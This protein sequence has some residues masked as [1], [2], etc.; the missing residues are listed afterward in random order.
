[1]SLI[2]IG[3]SGSNK[4][5]ITSYCLKRLKQRNL[6]SKDVLYMLSHRQMCYPIDED[7][8]QKIRVVLS[9]NKKAF[10]TIL[11]DNKKVLVITGGES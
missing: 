10:I 2:Y 9:N 4:V 8:R 11:E 6:S 5:F 7:G 3:K 1:M